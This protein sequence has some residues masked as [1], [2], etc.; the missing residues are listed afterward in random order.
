MIHI[1]NFSARFDINQYISVQKINDR[2]LNLVFSTLQGFVIRS[3]DPLLNQN[4][5][6][7]ALEISVNYQ[8]YLRY[9]SNYKTA[10]TIFITF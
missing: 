1:N 10:N 3:M 6:Y 5:Y 2:V 7:L 9:K 4:S 8:G